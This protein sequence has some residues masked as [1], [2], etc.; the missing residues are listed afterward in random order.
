MQAY[1][2]RANPNLAILNVQAVTLEELLTSSDIVS[3]NCSL[4]KKTEHIL[5]AERL[6]LMRPEAILVNTARGALIDEA[7][8]A[9]ALKEKRI[10][11]AA[12]DTFEV[13][14]LPLESPL[15][16]LSNV[17]LTPHMVG[18]TAETNQTILE[19]AW[20]SL[21][22]AASWQPPVFIKNPSVLTHWRS[23]E[24]S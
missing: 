21:V 7:A 13:E 24:L 14:P 11:Y 10:G 1:V 23:K 22:N 4:N 19:T 2:H 6:A 9:V 20:S 18:H 15:R 16:E 8:L 12:L 5:N 17:I 3:L